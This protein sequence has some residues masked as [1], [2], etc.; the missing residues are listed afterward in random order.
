MNQTQIVVFEHE[1]HHRYVFQ[2][3]SPEG[4]G[5]KRTEGAGPTEPFSLIAAKCRMSQMFSLL[6]NR[7]SHVREMSLDTTIE[8]CAG[9]DS[10]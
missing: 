9:D 10:D 8:C 1:L 6:Q 3:L 7:T 5:L 2:S 4:L